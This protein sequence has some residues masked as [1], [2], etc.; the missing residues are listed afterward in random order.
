MQAIQPASYA[1]NQHSINSSFNKDSHSTSS[2]FDAL[3]ISGTQNPEALTSAKANA[4]ATDKSLEDKPRATVSQDVREQVLQGNT[5]FGEFTPTASAFNAY[6]SS[7]LTSSAMQIEYDDK[8]QHQSAIRAYMT[9]QHGQQREQI[10]QMVG[11]DLF[12]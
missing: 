3:S 1:V 12:A 11:I 6:Q 4:Q 2:K 7:E 5:I 8:P 10:Q 9:V